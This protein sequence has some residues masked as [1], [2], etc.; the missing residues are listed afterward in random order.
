MK[1]NKVG[2]LQS[3]SLQQPTGHWIVVEPPRQSLAKKIRNKKKTKK[4]Q[5]QKQKTR[6]PLKWPETNYQSCSVKLSL[7]LLEEFGLQWFFW[8]QSKASPSLLNTQE[9]DMCVWFNCIY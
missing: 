2:E 9:K 3:L 8:I 5:K 1:E 4:K 7:R 6:M